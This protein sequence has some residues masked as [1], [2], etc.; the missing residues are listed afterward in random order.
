MNAHIGSSFDAFLEE[1]GILAEATSVAIKR[2]LAWQVAQAMEKKGLSKSEMARAMGT[3]RAALD[4]L[5][6]PKNT[7]V[8]LS[9]MESAATVL[10]RRLSIDLVDVA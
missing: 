4:R 6:D 8:T 5:L 2:V 7:S 1:E 9:T 3:S 10:G